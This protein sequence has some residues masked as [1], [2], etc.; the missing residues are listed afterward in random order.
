LRDKAFHDDTTTQI[1]LGFFFN[2]WLGVEVGYGDLGDFDLKNFG[3]VNFGG[4]PVSVDSD[5]NMEVEASHI[6]IVATGP[7]AGP[8]LID[9]K[10]GYFEADISGKFNADS[11]EVDVEGVTY[12]VNLLLPLDKYVDTGRLGLDL[13]VLSWQMFSSIEGADLHTISVGLNIDF[14]F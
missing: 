3:V 8:L 6:V 4:A 13:K 10:F 11:Y 1:Y 14:S 9:G 7:F 5:I 12:Q 2:K